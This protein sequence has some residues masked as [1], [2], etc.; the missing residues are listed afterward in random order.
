MPFSTGREFLGYLLIMVLGFLDAFL[1]AHPSLILRVEYYFP[2]LGFLTRLSTTSFLVLA[3]LSAFYVATGMILH[4]AAVKKRLV[5]AAFR[6]IRFLILFS[7]ALTGT[8]F[9][10]LNFT[11]YALLYWPFKAG[12]YMLCLLL[13]AICIVRLRALRRIGKWHLD[14]E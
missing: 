9:V 8:A 10:V 4:G 7:A 14:M 13:L 5:P 1:L 12:S 6:K 3:F 11:G 2:E